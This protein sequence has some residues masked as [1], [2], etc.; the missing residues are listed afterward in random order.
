MASIVQSFRLSQRGKDHLI[1]LRRVTGLRHW[2]VL[3]RWALCTSLREPT[4]PPL[5]TIPADSNVEMDWRTFGGAY[6]GV[7]AAL[8]RQRCHEDGLGTEPE[9]LATYFRLHLHRGLAYLATDRSL[10]DVGDL[11]RRVRDTSAVG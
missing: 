5:E 4:V 2:N 8:V 3:C 9:T 7:Y 1:K 6:E 11:L 10:Q